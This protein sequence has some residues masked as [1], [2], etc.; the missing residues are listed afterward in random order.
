[1]PRLFLCRHGERIDHVEPTWDKTAAVPEDILLTARG[2]RQAYEMG[3]ALRGK[4]ISVIYSSPY[5][6]CVCTAHSAAT[7]LGGT[8]RVCI[9]PGL[10][11]RSAAERCGGD[12]MPKML[13]PSQ[14][15]KTLPL[16]DPQQKAKTGVP[17]FPETDEAFYE[18]CQKVMRAIL[19]AHPDDTVL[20]VAHNCNVCN[21][22]RCLVPGVQFP[23]WGVTYASITE[24]EVDPSLHMSGEIYV[25]F[26]DAWKMQ[27]FA[28]DALLQ[29]RAGPSCRMSLLRVSDDSQ[30]REPEMPIRERGDKHAAV[31]DDLGAGG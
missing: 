12:P 8:A 7:A 27:K 29:S 13:A 18:R 11:Q 3:M 24:L 20:L 30:L 17:A 9:E 19:A 14:L 28:V 1:M 2:H 22:T 5:I 23:R 21:L 16:I 25:P 10:A 26:S 31:V 15:I 6:R 4:G